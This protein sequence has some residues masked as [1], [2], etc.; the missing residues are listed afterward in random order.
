MAK[1]YTTFFI[2][3]SLLFTGALKAQNVINGQVWLAPNEPA[4][5]ALVTVKDAG[6]SCMTDRGGNFKLVTPSASATL[7]ITHIGYVPAEYTA[8]AQGDNKVSLAKGVYQLEDVI[9]SSDI[10]YKYFHTISKVDLN[11]RPVR[12]SQELLRTVPGL[13]IAQHAGGGKAEQIFLRGF[14]IDHGTDVQVS[15][16]GLPVNM[17]SHG[18]GQG[19]ADLHFLIPELVKTIDY[20]KGPYYTE[21][22]NLNTAGYVSFQTIDQLENN[23]FQVEG[24]QFN[25]LRALAMVNI[26]PKENAKR[27]AFVASEFMHFD[28]P[29]QSGQNFNRFNLFGKYIEHISTNTKLTFLASAFSS[30]WDASGQVPQRAIDQKIIDRF[31]AIDNTEGGI[32]GRYNASVQLSSF[33]KNGNSIESQL[34]YSR[35]YFQLYSNFTFFLR[36]SINGDQIKQSDERDI[37]GFNTKYHIPF[38]IGN[39]KL[40]T[41]VGASI[42]YDKTYDTELSYTRQRSFLEHAKLGD[43]TESNAAIFIDQKIQYNQWLVNIGSRL[44]YLHFNYLDKLSANADA[45]QNKSIVSPKINVQYTFNKKFQAFVKAG[46]G[47]HSNDTRVVVANQGRQILPPAYGADLGFNF[48]PNKKLVLNAAVWY[49][50]LQQEFV[51]VGDEGIIEPSGR[52]RRVGLDLSGRYQM[53]KYLFA[54]ANINI[55][56]ARLIDEEKGEDKIPLAPT[57]TSTGGITY[58]NKTGWNGSIRYRYIKD[59]AANETNTVIAKGYSLLDGIINYTHRKYEVGLAVENV[60]NASWNEAQFD[61]ESRLMNEPSAIS[62]LHFTPGTPFFAKIKLAIML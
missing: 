7:I 6:Y 9:L 52:S 54:D 45:P 42:R 32:T 25:H 56:G 14:D 15:V 38:T 22:G 20:G 30:K 10:N 40:K 4:E 16:D 13:F 3:L 46:K 37:I 49:L 26:L 51:Y 5:G 61:T 31:G 62:E 8:T 47:F 23:R 27:S 36:D 1:C 17:V 39:T 44:D 35:Y 53:T 55:A 21:H 60:L 2:L 48:H 29:F 12:S 41:T 19:Y 28:G 43:I 58:A 59:R 24:G 18:H 57:F 11:I 50:F 33:L 34:Y